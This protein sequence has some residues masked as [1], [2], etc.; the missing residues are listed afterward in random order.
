MVPSSRAA[1]TC[2]FVSLSVAY[3]ARLQEEGLE[4]PLPTNTKIRL[5]KVKAAAAPTNGRPC[6]A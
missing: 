6:G 2:N 3:R 1:L 5:L 4:P